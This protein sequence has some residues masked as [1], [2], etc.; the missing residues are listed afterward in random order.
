MGKK[1][2]T[3]SF[4]VTFKV[5]ENTIR[6]IGQTV[7]FMSTALM[8]DIIDWAINKYL[9]NTWLFKPINLKISD[10]RRIIAGKR[11]WITRRNNVK[12]RSRARMINI[13]KGGD[14]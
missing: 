1:Y 13:N 7:P 12:Y 8:G 14:L 9:E 4:V 2:K 6:D 3:Y 5:L 11:S 10:P